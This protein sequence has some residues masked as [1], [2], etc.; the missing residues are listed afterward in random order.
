MIQGT[1]NLPVVG[2]VD[3]RSALLGGL[4]VV[5]LLTLPKVKD[6]VQPVITKLGDTISGVGGK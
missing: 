3:K 6:H 4:A 5:L 2:R 1:V